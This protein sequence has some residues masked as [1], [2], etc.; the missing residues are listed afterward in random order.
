MTIIRKSCKHIKAR[1]AWPLRDP[2]LKVACT[3]ALFAQ[4]LDHVKESEPRI[5]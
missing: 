5:C 4:V 3:D 2:L 1:I